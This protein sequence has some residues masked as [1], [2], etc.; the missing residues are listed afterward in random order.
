MEYGCYRHILE[1]GFDTFSKHCVL[2]G[3]ESAGWV[4]WVEEEKNR[5][6]LADDTNLILSHKFITSR[7]ALVIH[8]DAA[9]GKKSED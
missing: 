4:S 8:K 5:P 6:V 3:L 2:G 9:L 7:G 1:L